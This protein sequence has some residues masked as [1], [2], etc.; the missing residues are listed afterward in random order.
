VAHRPSPWLAAWRSLLAV[1]AA[2]AVACR[3]GS[4]ERGGVLVAALT[5]DPGHLN[6]AIT[7]GGGV[8]TAAALLYDGLVDLDEELRPIPALAERWEVEA[9]G[10]LYRFHLRP[11]VTWH[12]G[13]PFTASD[14]QFTFDSLLL[15]FHARTRASLG[16]ALAA[17]TTPD[18]LTVE[19]RFRHPY[20]PLLQQ[21]NVVEA[22]ILARHVYQGTDPLTA[23]ANRAPVGTGPYRF[24]AYAPDAEIRYEANPSYYRGAPAV[25]Q[26]ILRVIPDEGL[27][28]V[29]LEAGEVDWLFGVPGP[30]RA[31]LGRNPDI[32]FLE[33]GLNPGGSNCVSTLAFNLDRPLFRDVRVR[34]A[35]GHA[36]D[37]AQILERVLFGQGR[38]ATAPITSGIPFAHAAD[39]AVPAHDT[40]EA[41]RLLDAAG[42]P[43]GPDGIRVARGVAGMADGTRLAIRFSHFASFAAYADL[44]RAQLRPV[45]ID[46]I[47][48]PTEPAVFVDAV[49]RARD[50]DMGI[51]SYCQGT[52]P[53]IGARRMYVS[54]M[55]APVPFSNAA[56]YRN[57]E[58]D[59]L[60]N[61]AQRTLNEEARQR[62]YHRIQE[63]AI[64]DMPYVWLV[65]TRST[66]AYRARCRG[67][68]S[69]AHFAAGARCDP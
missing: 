41:N 7:T 34:R 49:F 43:R 21:L 35:L 69:A 27:Q 39:L 66:R 64:R 2:L 60:W 4:M 50:F 11:G 53:E 38:V 1:L 13:A 46:F 6:P 3:P 14:V 40:V 15:R 51:I 48:V 25:A 55:V 68:T 62:A 12:D 36:I 52:D 29:A 37:R 18:A 59:S 22:P 47:L 5:S 24:V 65:E 61:A 57:P 33:T 44:L 45:G 56:G 30:D 32:G 67:F 58:M 63:I 19:F 54:E 10:A 23:P 42:W 20:A 28:V 9:G 16:G 17:I 8:H 26:V 31:R